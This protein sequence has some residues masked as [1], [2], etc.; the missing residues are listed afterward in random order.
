MSDYMTVA[1]AD[2]YLA[3]QLNT[4]AWTATLPADKAKA[5]TM[6]TN[7]MDRLNY[8][9]EKT[10]SSQVNQFPRDADTVVPEEIMEACAD[11]AQR[12]AD[13]VDPELEFE[14]LMM[15]SQGYANVRSTYDRSTPPP[16]IV[17]GIVSIVAW[18][19]IKP[20]LRDGGSVAIHRVS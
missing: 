3:T 4:E 7:A 6:A 12:L 10:S 15:I 16:H 8:L 18:R 14:N 1:E 17:A 11:I 19:K 9:G 13:G 20:Y 2:I 5:L